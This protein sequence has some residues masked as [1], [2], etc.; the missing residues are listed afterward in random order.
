[1]EKRKWKKNTEGVE[2]VDERNGKGEEREKME[3]QE[4]Q[5]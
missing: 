4:I 2:R 3:G 5:G 1:M